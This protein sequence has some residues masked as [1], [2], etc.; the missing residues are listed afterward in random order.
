MEIPTA[1]FGNA[2]C[3]DLGR[4]HQ[5]E[6][7]H[8]VSLFGDMAEPSPISARLL[9]RYQSQVAG[10][11]L[12]AAKPFGLPDDQYEGQSRQRAHP[13]MR[14]QAPR[15]GTLLYFLLDRLAQLGDPW[16]Q[17]IQQ[18]QQIVSSLARPRS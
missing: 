17:S 18:L 8:G 14:H 5:Q 15:L 1:P 7:Q 3:G 13:G 10:N 12:A 4:F 9:Q 16:V 2:A 6:A 11:L